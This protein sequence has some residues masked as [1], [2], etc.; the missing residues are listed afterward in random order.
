MVISKRKYYRNFL[1][2]MLIT[3]VVLLFAA[4]VVDK[5]VIHTYVVGRICRK[6]LV[7]IILAICACVIMTLLKNRGIKNYVSK[8]ILIKSIEENLISIGA[9]TKIENKNFVML[10]KIKIRDNKIIIELSNLRIRNIL[11]R[12]M[13]SFSTA[14]PERYVVEDY[15]VTKN[16]AQIVISYED[17]KNFK[18]EKYDLMEYRKLTENTGKMDLYFDRKHVVNLN[19]HPH[20]L[21]SGGSGSGK[22]YLANELVIQA[23]FKQY[24][25][26][27]LDIKRSYGL[28]KDHAEYYY[29]TDAILQKI[30]DIENEMSER[31]E[32]LQPELDKNPHVLAVDIGYRPKLVVIEE[33]ISL[34]SSMDKK[35]KEEMERI[36][37]NISVLARQS[38]IHMLMVMQSAGTENINSTTRSN[39]TKVLMGRAQSN[40]LNATFGNSGVDIPTTQLNKGEGLIQLDRITVIRVPEI[41]DI[42]NFNKMI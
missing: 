22:S 19:D 35:Q 6:M 31:M 8:R 4:S 1:L 27:I 16:N 9:Y 42:E 21:L 15:Y 12:Y 36:V 10:P 37:K 23:I 20:I 34:L 38:N 17:V 3:G 13:N 30:R 14:L 29:E 18:P 24:E 41:M 33:Y 39:M 28:Y 26:V 2:T 32:K 25:V 7:M 40:I 11:D 5:Y